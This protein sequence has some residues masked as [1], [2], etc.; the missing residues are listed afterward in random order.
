VPNDSRPTRTGAIKNHPAGQGTQPISHQFIYSNGSIMAGT[1][2]RLP[3]Q[4]VPL[5]TDG[6]VSHPIPGDLPQMFKAAGQSKLHH[7]RAFFSSGQRQSNLLAGREV[8][9]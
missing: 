3:I 9:R 5:Q 8:K 6:G 7:L 4:C 1:K 2:L